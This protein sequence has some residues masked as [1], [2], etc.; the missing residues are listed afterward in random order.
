MNSDMNSDIVTVSLSLCFV[1]LSRVS[2][3]QSS[4]SSFLFA[5]K[6]ISLKKNRSKTE[7]NKIGKLPMLRM[8]SR[9]I[10]S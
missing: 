10:Y 8:K 7:I 1:C 2:Q 9:C 4:C 3:I 6:L 5:A